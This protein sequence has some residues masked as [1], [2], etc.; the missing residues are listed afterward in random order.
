MSDTQVQG[1]LELISAMYT[2]D[3]LSIVQS[4]EGT[5][6]SVKLRPHSGGADLQ[7]FA[8]CV[9]EIQLSPG[10]PEAAAQVRVHGT[11]GLVEEEEVRGL[12]EKFDQGE[13]AFLAAAEDT[14]FFE[15]VF[16]AE[17]E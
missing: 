17:K 6:V 7:R 4:A 16:A 2:S 14:D 8:E 9:M 11:R 1:E 12:E 13:T 10:Y 15:D 3:E 5:L